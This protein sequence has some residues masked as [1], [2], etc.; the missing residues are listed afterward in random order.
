MSPSPAPT[1][2]LQRAPLDTYKQLTVVRSK[3][4]AVVYEDS[5]G[6]QQRITGLGDEAISAVSY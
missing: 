2:G 4:D 1:D 6:R 3:N 5:Q